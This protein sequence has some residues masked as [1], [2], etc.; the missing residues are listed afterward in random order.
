LSLDEPVAEVLE[1]FSM[2]DERYRSVTVRMLLNHTSGFPGTNFPTTG[3]PLNPLT[4]MYKRRC[5]CCPNRS[6]TRIQAPM[7]CT[8]T[9][10]SL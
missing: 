5:G 9:M 1:G 7:P 3:S 4:C 8:A 2:A 6:Q 10:A